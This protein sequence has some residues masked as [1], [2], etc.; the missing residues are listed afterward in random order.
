MNEQTVK[1]L[2]RAVVRYLDG[3]RK[4]CERLG[5][6]AVSELTSNCQKCKTQMVKGTWC[7]T[8]KDRIKVYLCTAC[9]GLKQRGWRNDKE[10]E[11]K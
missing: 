10:C 11:H 7:I 8:K 6:I 1:L 9:G 3:D 4:E 5:G 2:T